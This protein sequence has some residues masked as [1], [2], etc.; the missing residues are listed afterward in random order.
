MVNFGSPR[1]APDSEVLEGIAFWY[2]RIQYFIAEGELDSIENAR[3]AHHEF[4]SE[5]E[6]RGLRQC[7]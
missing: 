3:K 4:V 5:A 7:P 6:R 1:N 2:Q